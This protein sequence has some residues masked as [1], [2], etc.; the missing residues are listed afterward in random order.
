M[1]IVFVKKYQALELL[2]MYHV[3]LLACSYDKGLISKP[4]IL[5]CSKS[6]CQI[7]Y[8]ARDSLI[9]TIINEEY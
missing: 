8:V 9:V 4:I 2:V 7:S 1:Y 6:F 5:Y 3:H